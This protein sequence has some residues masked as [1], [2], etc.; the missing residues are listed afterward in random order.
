LK[1]SPSA[2]YK[3]F[4]MSVQAACEALKRQRRLELRYDGYTRVVEVHAV[5]VSKDGNDIMRVW[6]V[7]GG[8]TGSESIGWK[9][10]RVR[11]ASAM[12]ILDES[13]EAPRDRYRRGDSAMAKIFCE[14]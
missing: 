5:G 7:R 14:I 12:R 4:A 10:L 2:T 8:S 6:Q 13:S 9:L 3:G 11:E 1:N